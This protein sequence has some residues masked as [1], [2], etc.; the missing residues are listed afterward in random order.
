MNTR[1][2]IGD[3]SLIVRTPVPFGNVEPMDLLRLAAAASENHGNDPGDAALAYASREETGGVGWSQKENSWT[4]PTPARPYST[5]TIRPMGQTSGEMEIARG[6]VRA[7]MELCKLPPHETARVEAAVAKTRG[8]GFRPSGVAINR[9]GFWQFCGFVPI[10]AMHRPLSIRDARAQFRYFHLWDWTLRLMHWM[11][12]V[13]VT[14][15]VVTGL[16]IAEGWFVKFGDLES[17]N[18]FGNVRRIHFI[19]G[20][21]LIAV[22]VTRFSCFFFASNKYQTFA[23]L[24]P[25]RRQQWIDLY[26]TARDYLLAKSFDGPRY[27]GHNPLQQWTYTGV[28]GLFAVMVVSGLALFAL[29][30]PH[31]WFYSWFMPLNDLLG[32]PYVRLVHVIGTW[33]FMLF[34]TIHVYL[35]I[36][37]GNVDRDGTISSMFS[38]GRWVRKGAD[39]HDE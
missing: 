18:Q 36:L 16:A 30:E 38:G 27:I 7:L 4:P 3:I 34:V 37:S 1:V 6:D 39:F 26:A 29:Y 24:F 13:C 21:V 28:Y 14:G 5:A 19:L 11:W 9:E 8:K 32:I 35:S 10:F 23:S 17:G 15:L 20:W 22:L 2:Q 25:I 33:C 12:V 31:H